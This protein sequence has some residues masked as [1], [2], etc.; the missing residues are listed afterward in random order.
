MILRRLWRVAEPVE[1]LRVDRV[2]REPVVH[3][4]LDD[5]PMRDLDRHRNVL[6]PSLREKASRNLATESS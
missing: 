4:A 6:G 1:L 2:D 3:E 5:R